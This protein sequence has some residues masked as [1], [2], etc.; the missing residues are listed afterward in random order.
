MLFHDFTLAGALIIYATEMKNAMNNHA[1]KFALISLAEPL[2]IRGHSVE[3]D[4]DVAVNMPTARIIKSDNIGEII[5][6]KEITIHLQDVLIATELIVNCAH[7]SVM[8]R[9]HILNPSA[10]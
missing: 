4:N 5:M 6:I 7:G 10:H 1:I 9:A 8:R 2:G 3:R